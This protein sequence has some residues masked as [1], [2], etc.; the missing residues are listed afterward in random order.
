ML[1]CFIHLYLI[2][3]MSLRQYF[4]LQLNRFLFHNFISLLLPF[5]RLFVSWLNTCRLLSFK[6]KHCSHDFILFNKKHFIVMN[7]QRPIKMLR[8]L[9]CFF[10][11]YLADV[12][13]KMR[14]VTVIRKLVYTVATFYILGYAMVLLLARPKENLMCQTYHQ[15]SGENCH[16]LN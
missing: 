1:G 16:S 14:E 4:Y 7:L 2:I 13:T 15:G 5:L 11:F 9:K 12:E 10:S 8:F 3:Y 6:K